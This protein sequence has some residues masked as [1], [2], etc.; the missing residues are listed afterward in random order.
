MASTI[1]YALKSVVE[2]VSRAAML[3]QPTNVKEF[4]SEYFLQLAEF[5][6]TMPGIDQAELAFHFEE[7]WEINFL[8]RPCNKKIPSAAPPLSSTTHCPKPPTDNAGKKTYRHVRTD[9]GRSDFRTC[10]VGAVKTNNTSQKS[11]KQ[12]PEKKVTSRQV[13]N[14]KAKQ[15]RELLN[16]AKAQLNRAPRQENLRKPH[17]QEAQTSLRAPIKAKASIRPKTLQKKD[18]AKDSESKKK[19]QHDQKTEKIKQPV[20]SR[21]QWMQSKT[22]RPIMR[23][24]DMYTLPLGVYVRDPDQPTYLIHYRR[25]WTSTQYIPSGYYY[26]S[27]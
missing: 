14:P 8:T 20:E 17:Q 5:R 10:Q 24:R 19:K 23:N 25:Q 1:P 22:E 13:L 2:C 27:G 3:A 26:E 4:V 9:K 16:S 18:G 15:T 12:I 6:K 21:V 11:G 7:Q